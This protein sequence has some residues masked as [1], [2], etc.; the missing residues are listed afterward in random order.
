MCL[1]GYHT[2]RGIDIRDIG[3]MRRAACPERHA[4]RAADGNRAKVSLKEG[5]PVGQMLLHKWHVIEGLHVQVLVVGQ[6]EDNVGTV[7]AAAAAAASN[8]ALS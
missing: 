2:I 8:R 7:T 1:V 3:I 6:D 5:A 4:R